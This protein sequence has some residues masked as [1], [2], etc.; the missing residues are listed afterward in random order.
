M[1]ATA[2]P[3][4]DWV[5]C[6]AEVRTISDDA[7]CGYLPVPLDR[8]HPGGRKIQ[9]YFERYPRRDRDGKRVGTVVSIEGG[10]GYPTTPDRSGRA[11]L[12]RPISANR[13]LVLVDLRGTGKSGALSCPAYTKTTR[14]YPQRGGR[15]AKQIG[16]K[17]DFYNTSQ[18]VKDVEAVLERLGLA[19]D[20]DLYGDS[21]GSYAAQ[22]YALRYPGRL[23]SLV[24]DGTYPV[25]GTDPAWSDLVA[26][27]RRGYRLT[28]RRH[29]GCPATAHGTDPVSLIAGFAQQVRANPIVGTAPNGDGT[30]THVRLTEK[31]LAWMAGATYYYYASYR[32]L[33]AAIYASRHGDDAPI[34]RLAA[35]TYF[36]DGGP[37]DPP[38]WSEALYQ[39]VTCHDYPQLW[40]PATPISGRVAEAKS[41]IAA[42]PPGT[43]RPFSAAAWTGTDYEGAL[44]CLYWPS[45]ATPDPP[46]PPGATYPNVPTLVLNGDLDTITPSADAH[47]VADNFPN[48]HFV[49]VQNSVHVTALY[50]NDGCASRIYVH[51]VRK[52]H[53]GDTSCASHIGEIHTVSKFPRWLGG[54]KPAQPGDG[55]GSTR[56]D[57]R[58]ATV[59]AATVAD[60]VERWWVNYDTTSVGLRGGRWSY[61]GA[62]PTNF[63]LDGVRFVRNVG[64]SGKAQ[65][66]LTRGTVDAHVSVE[67]AGTAGELHLRWPRHVKH[68]VAQISGQIAGR[69][70]RASM[71][72]P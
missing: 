57:R 67:A 3:P 47:D 46:D 61:T 2:P 60:V 25:P 26:A 4:I 1:P 32:D 50:D 64:V 51:F 24:L 40:S 36:K 18:S 13:D 8:T 66:F 62:D 44:A 17:R 43:F 35:E 14:P 54:V 22:A 63:H 31:V 39:A 33:Q 12:W 68:S 29:P 16:P 27:V 21:Y 59:A 5:K 65:W 7:R 58:I 53:T 42:Y 9:I 56:R 23:R 41:Q 15:C 52:L 71:L 45:P 72:A 10:P 20:V 49:E 28:C 55:D 19:H 6:P 48:S 38:S 11:A 70:L 37:I 69:P 30:P 34:L